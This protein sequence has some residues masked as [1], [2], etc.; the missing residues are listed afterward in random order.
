MTFFFGSAHADRAFA[1]DLISFG[2][3]IILSVIVIHYLISWSFEGWMAF[4]NWRAA[5]RSE[6]VW[7]VKPWWR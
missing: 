4:C 5:R 1:L 2:I 7:R 6:R 3:G